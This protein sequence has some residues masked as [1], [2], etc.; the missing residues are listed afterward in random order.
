MDSYL[1][2]IVITTYN[3]KERLINQLRS[4]FRQPEYVSVRI[5][6]LD[7]N[8]EYDVINTFSKEFSEKEL[9]VVEVIRRP[10]NIGLTGN[11]STSF[12]YCKTKWMWLLSDDDETEENSIKTI[13]YDIKQHEDIAVIKYS[14][15][16]FV[17]DEDKIISTISEYIEYYRSGVHTSGNMIFMS[18]NV[19]NLEL[20]LPYLG[21]ANIHSYTYIPHLIPVIRGLSDNAIKMMFTSKS[22][23]SFIPPT[24]GTHWD[25]VP[26]IVGLA[27]LADIDFGLNKTNHHELCALAVRDFPHGKFIYDLLSVKNRWKRN[28]YY[29]R[30]FYS[31]YIHDKKFHW[32][33]F[34]IFYIIHFLRINKGLVAKIKNS[35]R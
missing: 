18:N 34:L 13:L 1:L 25:F 3:R 2:T 24:P 20:L 9:S 19:F 33:F 21:L 35:S 32:K 29:K 28:Y 30:V 23:V 17:P 11:L 26:A 8:S 27:S 15:K 12:M 6:I 16:K 31:L 10:Y 14:I 4:I 5:I 7:N 22:I